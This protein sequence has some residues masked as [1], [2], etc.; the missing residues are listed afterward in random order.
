MSQSI[1]EKFSSHR[2][3]RK[4]QTQSIRDAVSDI[5]KKNPGV[6]MNAAAQMFANKKGFSIYNLLSSEDKSSLRNARREEAT[7]LQ[8]TPNKAKPS[9]RRPVEPDFVSPFV[10]EANNN[11]APYVYVYLLENGLRQLILDSFGPNDVTWWADPMKVPDDVRQY[12]EKIQNA[13]KKY[14]WLKARGNHPIYY[15]GLGELFRIIEN[16]W[17]RVFKQAFPDLE[18]LRG[19]MKES[20]PIRNIIA[21]NVATRQEERL[22]IKIRT[23][24]VCRLIQKWYESRLP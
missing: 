15:V 1:L 9:R 20:V 5:H 8:M 22:N 7:P 19:W 10:R 3:T 12:S 24:Y 23:D 18:Q 16:S 4:M 13:E 21:H 11:S 14:R 2:K 6:T 17:K